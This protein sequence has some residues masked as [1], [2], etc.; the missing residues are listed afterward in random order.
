MAEVLQ[1]CWMGQVWG[2]LQGEFLGSAAVESSWHCQAPGCCCGLAI[3]Q[4]QV[5]SPVALLLLP[6]W[7]EGPQGQVWVG[8][9]LHYKGNRLRVSGA[10]I[11]CSCPAFGVA[12]TTPLV[13]FPSHGLPCFSVFLFFPSTSV[14]LR[15]LV[16]KPFLCFCHGSADFQFTNTKLMSFLPSIFQTP[17]PRRVINH[18]CPYLQEPGLES[19]SQWQGQQF[20]S[21]APRSLLQR[22]LTRRGERPRGAG[23]LQG[24]KIPSYSAGRKTLVSSASK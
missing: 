11:F 20:S 17:R 6:V 5:C 19:R 9:D 24:L 3:K 8:E 1:K 18:C 7:Q 14:R 2:P 23:K 16:D 15:A 4:L 21:S 10:L 13:P 12:I 22:S